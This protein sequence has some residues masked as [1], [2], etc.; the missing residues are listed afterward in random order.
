MASALHKEKLFR[1][2]LDAEGRRRRQRS[3]PRGALVDPRNSPW[4]GLCDSGIDQ[5]LIT[6]K[7]LIIVVSF[8]LLL[9]VF[10][11]WFDFV[12]AKMLPWAT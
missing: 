1:D 7:A 6:T 8:K 9:D 12:E 3:L 10:Q 4:R 11:P 2:M 5:A